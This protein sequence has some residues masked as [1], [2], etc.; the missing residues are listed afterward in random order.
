MVTDFVGLIQGFLDSY[1]LLAVFVLL[2]L[3][4]AMLLPLF[5][6]E[7]LLV[8]AANRWGQ[9]PVMLGLV[10]VVASAAA[11]LGNLL[12]YGIARGAGRGFFERH[13]K[14][15]LMSPRTRDKLERL[16]QRPAGQ[17]LALFLRL[18]PL[19]RLLVSLPAGLAR[20]PVKRFILLSLIG[21]A[22]FNAG[23]MYVARDPQVATATN[24]YATP[25]W[26]FVQANW[27]LVAVSGVG[28]GVVLSFK[29]ARKAHR[30][31]LEAEGSFLGF[32]ARL[33]LF[34]GGIAVLVG[35]WIE[36]TIVYQAFQF[37]GLDLTTVAPDWPFAP[38]SVA[39]AIGLGALFVW[40]IAS[41]IWRGARRRVKHAKRVNRLKSQLDAQPRAVHDYRFKP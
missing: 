26:V 12:V 8:I 39:A 7:V 6:G 27:A 5:P 38:A 28:L 35:L 14:L 23:F 41:S 36:P 29:A 15:F 40:W 18:V 32:L 31:P 37:A 19:A 22:I 16:F 13:P 1:G 30:S 34:W 24:T 25:A 10:I 4:S 11:T 21:N 9:T 2:T 3:D 33:V 20:M 17:S